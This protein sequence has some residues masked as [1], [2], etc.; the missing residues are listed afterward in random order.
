MA[1]LNNLY[2]PTM[3][4][5][6]PG[7]IRT[8]N[9]KIYF[10]ISDYNSQ[11]DISN[12]QVSLV[13]VKTN[14]SAFKTS[15][16]PSGIKLTELQYDPT[17]EDDYCYFI[18]INTSDL[19][20]N[21]FA[22]NEYYKVQLRFTSIN[23]AAISLNTP[24]AISTWLNENTQYFSEWSR[25]CLLRGISN[26]SIVLN[27]LDPDDA[28]VQNLMKDVSGLYLD[29]QVATNYVNKAKNLFTKIG[30]PFDNWQ[31]RYGIYPKHEKL[32]CQ[33]AFEYIT[34]TFSGGLDK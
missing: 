10:S 22:L 3:P 13:D 23:A 26:P 28:L 4:N 25:S 31:I 8:Q 12:V 11:R 27:D 6:I 29:S 1:L 20:G 16:Y 33:R 34:D 30:I 18:T 17:I 2:P 15:L 9:C 24:Q 14:V 7:F 21:A 19:K 32:N 5:L